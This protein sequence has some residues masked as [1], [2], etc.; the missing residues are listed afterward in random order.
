MRGE[1]QAQRGGERMMAI[2]AEGERGRVYLP[3]T[4]EMEAIALQAHAEWRPEQEMNQESSNLVSGRGYGIQGI[5]VK[6]D[7]R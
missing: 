2:V 6:R 3:P 4:P 7:S 1:F 5:H